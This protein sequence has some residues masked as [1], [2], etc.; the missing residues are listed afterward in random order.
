MSRTLRSLSDLPETPARFAEST[1]VMIDCQV[2]YTRGPLQLDGVETA[3]DQAA[4]LLHR[5]RT[6]GIPVIHSWPAS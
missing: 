5:A 3:L 2:T 1:L 6:T 4:A